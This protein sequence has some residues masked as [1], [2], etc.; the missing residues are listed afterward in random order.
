MLRGVA[1]YF[2]HVAKHFNINLLKKVCISLARL[3]KNDSEASARIGCVRRP[4]AIRSNAFLVAKHAA[5]WIYNASEV[6]LCG[7]TAL[8][9]KH[10]FKC[11]CY[12]YVIPFASKYQIRTML[13]KAIFSK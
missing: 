12:F 7:V 1:Q 11:D 10:I 6:S 8:F 4:T 13:Q 5:S 3:S 2:A 9:S